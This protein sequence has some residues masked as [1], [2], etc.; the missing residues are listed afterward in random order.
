MNTHNHLDVTLDWCKSQWLNSRH[1]SAWVLYR[2]PRPPEGVGKGGFMILR[3]GHVSVNALWR[4]MPP[5][6]SFT[7]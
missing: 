4:G 6:Q 1:R 2:P 7:K 3:A 5:K